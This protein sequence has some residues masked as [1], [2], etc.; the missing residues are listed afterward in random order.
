MQSEHQHVSGNACLHSIHHHSPT[1]IQGLGFP[2]IAVKRAVPPF[3]SM[4]D[5]GLVAEPVFSFWL[6]RN[7]PGA[8]GGELILGG[9]DP[10]H[11]KGEHLWCVP[12][13]MPVTSH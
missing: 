10:A 7:A 12:Y 5:Q 11:Y 13:T 6:N 8:P 2:E 3:I 1:C 4:V 9:V